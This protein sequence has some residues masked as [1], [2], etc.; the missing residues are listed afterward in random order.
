[1]AWCFDYHAI[2]ANS[3]MLGLAGID[4][5][6]PNPP[7]GLIGRGQDWK[8][9][10]EVY[11]SAAQQVWEAVPEVVRDRHSDVR[12]AYIDL[13]MFHGFQ[14]IHDLKSQPWL[15][16]ELAK[17]VRDRSFNGPT[18]SRL[19]LYPLLGDLDEMLSGRD[20]W[21]SDRLR[22]G[23]GKIFVDGTLN[24]R[25]AWM[26]H[27]FADGR[28]DHPRGTPMMTPAQIEDAVRQCDA[29]GLPLAAHA[30]GD[31]AVRAVLDAI[32]TVR[33]KTPGFRIEHAEIID[34]ADVP[35]FAE[36][37]VIASVQP[38]HLLT[39]IEALRKAMPDRLDRVLPLRELIDAGCAPGTSLLFGSDVPIVRA[40][41]EDSILAATARQREGSPAATAIAPHQAIS[42]D[43]AW[44]CF[45][46]NLTT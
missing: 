42:K 15:G 10:G 11:E 19:I 36:L 43:E 38:C 1:M 21:E 12:E 39:D 35:R 25:T 6:T 44:Q 45:R 46:C 32:E 14:E 26:L 9:T 33:P 4:D 24:S 3:A 22:L 40:D 23:G 30:I 17:I 29:A 16:Y 5:C 31:G 2:M 20:D 13:T 27:P 34:Q 7:G 37:G 8:P 18:D 41:P 28:P